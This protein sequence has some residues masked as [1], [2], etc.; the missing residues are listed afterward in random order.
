MKRES[1]VADRRE[2][3]AAI[4]RHRCNASVS[5]V[6]DRDPAG[7]IHETVKRL[8]CAIACLANRGLGRSVTLRTSVASDVIARG[9][10]PVILAGPEIGRPKGV[11]WR[12]TPISLSQFRGGGV[13]ACLDGTAASGGLVA[14]ALQWAQWLG[15]PMIALTVAEPIPSLPDQEEGR[16]ARAF[17]PDG[18]VDSFLEQVLAPA[19][20]ARVEVVGVPVY[21]PVGPAEGVRSYLEES[22]AAL[23][24][25]GAHHRGRNEDVA[26]GGTAAAIVFRS[27]SPVLVVP[28]ERR[29]HAASPELGTGEDRTPRRSP[30]M[31]PV[32][33]EL[34]RSRVGVVGR[35]ARSVWRFPPFERGAHRRFGGVRPQA[36]RRGGRSAVPGGRFRAAIS[37]SSWPGT[38][39]IVE[40]YGGEERVISVHGP[41]RF[42][43]ELNLLTGQA[44]FLTAVVREPGEVLVV[45]V[46]R[47][48]EVLAD[49]PRSGT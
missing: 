30:Q 32:A 29:N 11:W 4:G 12:D 37:L 34:V 3:L 10:D 14:V 39:A 28:S 38:V 36:T 7:V 6:V 33:R 19:Q 22:P 8:R 48:R 35:D 46:E 42:L 31:R 13:V 44:V 26:L 43:G 1:D 5:V 17:E 23:V 2:M 49:D 25:V 21:D 20:G 27:R 41:G 9:G 40:G 47:L 24:V 18:N 15:E 45:P 16:L